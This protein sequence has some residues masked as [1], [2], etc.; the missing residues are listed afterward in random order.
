MHEHGSAKE[1]LIYPVIVPVQAALPFKSKPKMPGARKQPTLE[2]K[3]AVVLE[4]AERRTI[5][6]IDQLNALRNEKAAKKRAKQA[7]QRK[8]K[9]RYVERG[10]ADK[11]AAA[12]KPRTD[13]D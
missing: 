11:P 1:T 3:R 9:K 6:L 10:A 13:D 2:Q 8:R 7:R 12:K 4:T 5:A